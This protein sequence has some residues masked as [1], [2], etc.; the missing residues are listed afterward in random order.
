MTIGV[1]RVKGGMCH[2]CRWGDPKKDGHCTRPFSS[3]I[4]L[5]EEEESDRAQRYN[6]FWGYYCGFWEQSPAYAPPPSGIIVAPTFTGKYGHTFALCPTCGIFEQLGWGGSRG[7][8]RSLPCRCN[9]FCDII[10]RVGS[11]HKQMHRVSEKLRGERWSNVS[12][13]NTREYRI[14]SKADADELVCDFFTNGCTVSDTIMREMLRYIRL[15][16]VY[17]FASVSRQKTG[18]SWKHGVDGRVIFSD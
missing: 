14:E 9:A 17:P 13:P 5:L 15:G 8:R 2:T 16:E 12:G 10:G 3:A 4:E 6:P 18:V 7:E 11:A 1:P